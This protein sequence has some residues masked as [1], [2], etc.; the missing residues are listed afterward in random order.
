MLGREEDARAVLERLAV[1]D[2]ADVPEHQAWGAITWAA[3]SIA[4]HLGDHQRAALLYDLVLPYEGSLVF[5]GLVVFDTFGATLGMLAATL[6]R[7]DDAV[8]HFARAEALT[9]RIGAPLL[10]AGTKARRKTAL[11]DLPDA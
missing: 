4:A 7:T 5:P 6:G 11:P 9:E 10:L 8:A 1:D 3:S 2:F